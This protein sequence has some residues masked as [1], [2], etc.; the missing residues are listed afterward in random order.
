MK[1]CGSRGGRQDK[2]EKMALNWGRRALA[3]LGPANYLRYL[4]L[5]VIHLPSI[6]RGGILTAVDRAMGRTPLRVRY[7]GRSFT[8]DCAYADRLLE[9]DSATFGG[10]REIYIR[11]CYLRGQAPEVLAEMKTVLDLGANRGVFSTLM[12]AFGGFVVCVECNP[13][14]NDFIRRNMAVNGLT[15]YAIDNAFIGSGGLNYQPG[16]KVLGLEELINRHGLDTVDF[17]KMDIEGSEFSLFEAPGWLRRVKYLAMEVHPEFGRVLP[18]LEALES[19]GFVNTINDYLF[20][21]V[22]DP[23]NGSFIYAH[24]G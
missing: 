10:V 2:I 23:Q 21:P 3:V 11:D 19:E 9:E 13:A 7:G 12:A 18:L 14:Y 24:R 6:W 1:S 15:N 4:G 22:D 17:I 20:H 16:Q 8:I 5:S